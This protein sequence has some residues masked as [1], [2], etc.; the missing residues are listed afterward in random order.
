MAMVKR[1]ARGSDSLAEAEGIQAVSLSPT[2][3][4]L[5]NVSTRPVARQ[6]L[7]QILD[8]VGVVTYAESNQATVSARFGGRIEKLYVNFTGDLVRRGQPLFELHSPDLV[9]AEQEYV[10]ALQAVENAGNTD[11]S[12]RAQ[13]ESLLQAIHERLMVHFGL[14]EGQIAAVA[15]SR[16][17]HSNAVF[18]SPMRG[19]V[20]AKQIQEGQYVSEG[21]V[22]YQ[23]ADLST[24]WVII[25]VYESS[26]RS[27][28]VG[29][30]VVVT[31]EAY[32]NETFS[33]RV[34]FIDPSVDPE[35]RTVRVRTEFSNPGG[36]LRPQM[37]V[38]ARVTVPSVP[39]LVIPASA[40]LATGRRNV[41][42]VE[43]RPNVFEPRDVVLGIRTDD[44]CQVLSGLSEGEQVAVTGGFMLDSES[45]LQQPA[46]GQHQPPAVP[47]APSRDTAVPPAEGGPR[48]VRID[49]NVD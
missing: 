17:V 34:T 35:N 39:G 27:V 6:A 10:L 31:T 13:Q 29:Q 20:I 23:L 40:V 21:M 12:L 3:R 45:Q 42:W 49:V 24:V 2:Q 43:V 26:I 47:A 18:Y 48:A 46:G 11:A 41:V 5:A 32:P 7:D 22:L 1:S 8:A 4:V 36:K 19:T 9:S 38:R 30:P 37:F 14:T 16:S 15:G 25:D 44:A 33:G 28:R